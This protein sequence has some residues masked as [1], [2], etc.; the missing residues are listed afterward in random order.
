MQLTN[1]TPH[2]PYIESMHDLDSRRWMHGQ[3]VPRS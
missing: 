3:R 2:E 1:V